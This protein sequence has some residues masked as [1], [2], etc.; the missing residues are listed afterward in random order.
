[1]HSVMSK[2]DYDESDYVVAFIS[3][4]KL[5]EVMPR[6]W[7]G[8]GSIYDFECLSVRG[9]SD[10]QHYLTQLYGDYMKL[11]PEE[12]RSAQTQKAPT[13][14]PYRSSRLAASVPADQ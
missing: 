14:L 6:A 2:Y 7:Y 11:P 8:D 3:D 5:R 10:P 1:M 4:Y 13:P 9:V 12:K